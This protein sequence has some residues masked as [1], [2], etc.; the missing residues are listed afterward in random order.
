MAEIRYYMPEVRYYMAEVRWI[1]LR[2]QTM[3]LMKKLK[4]NFFMQVAECSL[5]ACGDIVATRHGIT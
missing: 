1:L 5:H 3:I 2:N 4:I